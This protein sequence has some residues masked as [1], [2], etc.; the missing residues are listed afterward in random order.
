MQRH[1]DYQED[2][3]C[4]GLV[5]LAAGTL[6]HRIERYRPVSID[7]N[8]LTDSVPGRGCRRRW[9]I[10][11]SGSIPCWRLCRLWRCIRCSLASCENAPTAKYA[12]SSV[13]DLADT[14]AALADTAGRAE[15]C[16]SDRW[17]PMVGCFA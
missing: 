3:P 1:I 17:V 2:V 10:P 11:C 14:R 16:T 4:L 12:V 7:H 15:A 9:C 5:K 6:L 13:V 8:R